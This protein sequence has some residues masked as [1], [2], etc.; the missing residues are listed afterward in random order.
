MNA[1]SSVSNITIQYM[2]FIKENPGKTKKEINQILHNK[3]FVSI[4][5]DVSFDQLIRI[6]EIY[7]KSQKCNGVPVIPFDELQW[8]AL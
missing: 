5:Y 8:Y 3:E 1:E 2:D 4:I 6:G 7:H